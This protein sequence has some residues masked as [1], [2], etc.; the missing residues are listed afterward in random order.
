MKLLGKMVA[1]LV[2]VSVLGAIAFAA[3]LTL[4]G[5]AALFSA[6]D[7]AVATVTGTACLVALV[8][9]W[10]IAHSLRTVV[11][12][13]T[14]TALREEKTATYQ[15]FVDYWQARLHARPEAPESLKM[16]E[17]LLALYGAQA[18]I[19]AHTGLRNLARAGNGKHADLR[20]RFTEALVAIRRDLGADT[21]GELAR[22][23]E[24]LMLPAAADGGDA[25]QSAHPSTRA[26]PVLGS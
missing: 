2:G 17:R 22:D 11:R 25:V 23:L 10:W 13:G 18:V 24:R 20:P 21:P 9:A 1:V 4:Q 16:L 3:Y 8:A 14:P 15:L 7:P 19:R 5:I 12:Q 26:A 6:L